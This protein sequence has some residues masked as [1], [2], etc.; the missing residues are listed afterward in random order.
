MQLNFSF[1]EPVNDNY[2]IGI[3]VVG[4]VHRCNIKV[5]DQMNLYIDL[6][7]YFKLPVF[8]SRGYG[9]NLSV[10]FREINSKDLFA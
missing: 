3:D 5:G 6:P 7:P 4:G 8:T 1:K 9:N 10:T 2:R